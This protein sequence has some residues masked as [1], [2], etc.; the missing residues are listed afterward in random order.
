MIQGS[1]FQIFDLFLISFL[2]DVFATILIQKKM[3]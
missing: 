3:L 2:V 1:H